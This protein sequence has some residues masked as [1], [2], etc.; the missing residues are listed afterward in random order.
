M[1]CYNYIKKKTKQAWDM[2]IINSGEE[3]KYIAH[4]IVHP[5]A[6]FFHSHNNANTE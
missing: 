6:I 2:P 1:N 5:W 3:R 4:Y